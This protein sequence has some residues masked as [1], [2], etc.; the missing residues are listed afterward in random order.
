MED[1]KIISTVMEMRKA[2]EEYD[3]DK[4]DILTAKN[5]IKAIAQISGIDPKIT[6]KIMRELEN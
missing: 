1:H 4:I 6:M 2:K 5:R 3:N